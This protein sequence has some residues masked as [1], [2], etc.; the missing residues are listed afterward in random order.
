LAVKLWDCLRCVS[1]LTAVSCL[2]QAPLL[3]D[4]TW[5]KDARAGHSLRGFASGP[6]PEPA[7]QLPLTDQFSVMQVIRCPRCSVPAGRAEIRKAIRV[8]GAR[9]CRA[10]ADGVKHLGLVSRPVTR[11][12]L[13]YLCWS[14][15]QRVPPDAHVLIVHRRTV[16]PIPRE[17]RSRR[18]DTLTQL[19][20]RRPLP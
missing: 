10:G 13:F 19:S 20:C 1:I 18:C 3:S 6:S 4:H 2:L 7:N 11:L 16:V 8:H 15:C 14:N 5:P 17:L 9:T 12:T